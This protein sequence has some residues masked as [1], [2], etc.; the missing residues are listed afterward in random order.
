[1]H[2]NHCLSSAKSIPI[3]EE[4]KLLFVDEAASDA[5]RQNRSTEGRSKLKRSVDMTSSGKNGLNIRTN[6]SPKWNRTRCPEESVL[7]WL[8]ARVAMFY[9]PPKFGNKVKIGIKVQF[10]NKFANRCNV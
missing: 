9:G 1:M 4:Q 8:A 10:G 2:I 3:T 6:A 5:E 7:C